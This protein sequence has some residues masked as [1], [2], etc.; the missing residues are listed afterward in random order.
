MAGVGD[1][2]TTLWP[3]VRARPA[4]TLPPTSQTPVPQGNQY[5][6]ILTAHAT[7]SELLESIGLRRRRR[8]L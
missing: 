5:D 3:I 6:V 1:F 8:A 4:Q 2:T 7:T